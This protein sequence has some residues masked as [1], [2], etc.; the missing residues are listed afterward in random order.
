MSDVLMMALMVA[1]FAVA[2]FYVGL[3][4]RL[5]SRPDPPHE[6]QR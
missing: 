4:D 5:A 3:C 1:A 2:A 6:D